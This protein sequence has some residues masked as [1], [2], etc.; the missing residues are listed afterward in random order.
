MTKLT[1]AE[2][3]ERLQAALA[4]LGEEDCDEKQYDQRM[5]WARI[6]LQRAIQEPSAMAN[7]VAND[8]A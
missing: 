4:I 2:A 1:K 6:M 3:S 5:K 7:D 8:L